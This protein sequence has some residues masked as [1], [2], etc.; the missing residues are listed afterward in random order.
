MNDR[1]N[2]RITD[3]LTDLP[4]TICIEKE[5]EWDTIPIRGWQWNILYVTYLTTF[6][7]HSKKHYPNLSK[8]QF[9]HEN[10]LPRVLMCRCIKV[11][12][13]WIGNRIT[14]Y[15]LSGLRP[16]TFKSTAGKS[17]WVYIIKKIQINTY[18]WSVVSNLTRFLFSGFFLMKPFL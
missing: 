16:K 6:I 12:L 11:I 3:I 10:V 5:T 1:L 9:R 14:Q 4:D 18:S 7:I 13:F 15:Y 8:S 2:N 17:F